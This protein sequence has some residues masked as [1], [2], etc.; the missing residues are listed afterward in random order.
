V[1]SGKQSGR[2]QARE[3]QGERRKRLKHGEVHAE[4]RGELK[5]M[6]KEFKKGKS[7][8]VEMK[9]NGMTES[10]YKRK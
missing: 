2:I 7:E 10:R 6:H 3:E 1:P 8:R 9:N 5:E 4:N